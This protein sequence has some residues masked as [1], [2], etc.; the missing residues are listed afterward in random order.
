MRNLARKSVLTHR[1]DRSGA[2]HLVAARPSFCHRRINLLS[3]FADIRSLCTN[4]TTYYLLVRL[5]LKVV[6]LLD[7]GLVG[8]FRLIAIVARIV[9]KGIAILLSKLLSNTLKRR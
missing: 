8:A 7:R 5:G 4:R 6:T 3:R 2:V 1:A 9:V